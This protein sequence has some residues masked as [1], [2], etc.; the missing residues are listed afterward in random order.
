M[1]ARQQALCAM[2]DK[3]KDMILQAERYIWAHPQTGY[4]EW[5]ASDYLA[6][7]FTALGYDVVKAGNIPGFYADIDTG[8]PGPRIL[9]FGELDALYCES[10]PEA[11]EGVVHACG[12]NCQSAALLGFAAALKEPGALEGMCGSIRLMSVPA[13]ELIEIEYRES[14]RKQGVIKYLGG[15]VEFMARGYFDGCDIA[16]MLHTGGSSP[17]TDY[18]GSRGQNGCM[19]KTVTYKGKAAHAGGGPH[20]GINALYA[21][22]L[23]MQAVNSLR[24]TFKDEDHIRF[25]PILTA[26]GT[27]VNVIPAETKIET[28]V[29]GASMAAIK[30]ANTRI[31]R[32]LTGAALAMGAGVELMD[33]PG[34]APVNADMN[35]LDLYEQ[36]AGELVGPERVKVNRARW[37]TCSTDMGDVS[38]VMPAMHPSCSGASGTAHGKDYFVTDPYRACCNAAKLYMALCDALLRDEAAAAKKILDSFTPLYPSIEAYLQE[39][40]SMIMDKDAVRYDENGNATV[41]FKN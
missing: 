38:C 7:K 15:K 9:V 32:A 11:R 28:Y 14:L 35:L 30:D 26:G 36:V 12:H 4:R 23:G 5:E 3:H 39:M 8:K 18:A 33:R 6:E 16:F 34:Y 17:D 29:R 1:N 25:H 27:A 22:S 24:E 19:A 40:D 21:A 2:V 41:D 10:H 20:N 31:N 13:E 37:G